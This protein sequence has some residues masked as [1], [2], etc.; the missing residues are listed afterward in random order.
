MSASE[1]NLRANGLGWTHKF[2]SLTTQLDLEAPGSGIFIN[3]GDSLIGLLPLN[4]HSWQHQPE[5]EV[6]LPAHST[7][8]KIR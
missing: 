8:N 7:G 5:L 4:V 1:D 2:G 6:G 3:S